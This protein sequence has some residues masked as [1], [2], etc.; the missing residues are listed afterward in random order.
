[1]YRA[2]A[3]SRPSRLVCRA[4]APASAGKQLASA[5]SAVALAAAL[6]LSSVEPAHADIS[7]LTPCADSAR[8]AKRQKAEIKLLEKRLKQ[9]GH[10][11]CIST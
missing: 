3:T 8:F 4:Q 5:A 1:M 2:Q 9:V 7:G 6:T 10:I 11:K